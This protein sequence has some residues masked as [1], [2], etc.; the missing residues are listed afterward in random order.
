[1]IL[2]FPA[3][4]LSGHI[5]FAE[6]LWD[7]VGFVLWKVCILEAHHPTS[8]FSICLSR[9]LHLPNRVH[10]TTWSSFVLTHGIPPKTV[11]SSGGDW[12]SGRGPYPIY[13][14]I[15]TKSYIWYIYN[16]YLHFVVFLCKLVGKYTV[17][18]MDPSWATAILVFTPTLAPRGRNW[19]SLV[20]T[21]LNCPRYWNKN[22]IRKKSPRFFFE[23]GIDLL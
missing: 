21:P 22:G 5:F 4:A 19:R 15:H 17:C 6:E 18:P 2:R 11:N 9:S 14:Y 1:M 16:L 7:D 13:T 3:L 20:W 23:V 10:F 12:H 8:M